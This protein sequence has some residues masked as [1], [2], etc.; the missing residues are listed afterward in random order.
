MQTPSAQI[1]VQRI[2]CQYFKRLYLTI[3]EQGIHAWCVNCDR[4][5][6]VPREQAI[7][8]LQ[9]TWQDNNQARSGACQ[10]PKV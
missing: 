2:K 9:G 5:H 6:V 10:A 7:A 3:D 1:P 8:M 4:P